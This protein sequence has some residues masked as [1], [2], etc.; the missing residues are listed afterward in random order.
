MK[1][2]K[3]PSSG[4]TKTSHSNGALASRALILASLLPLLTLSQ[5]LVL[6]ITPNIV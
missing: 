2:D 6:N 1:G 3:Q 4:K 5:S